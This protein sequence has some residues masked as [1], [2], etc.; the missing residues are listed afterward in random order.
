MSY[1]SSEKDGGRFPNFI[2]KY[3][4]NKFETEEYSPIFSPFRKS[5]AGIG[6]GF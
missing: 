4:K 6:V 3:S 1:T 2:G 5:S